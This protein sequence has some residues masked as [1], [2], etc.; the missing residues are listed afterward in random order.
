MNRRTPLWFARAVVAA[1]LVAACGSSTVTSPT[2]T[3]SVA[4]AEPTRSPA[5][6]LRVDGMARVIASA[7]LA[8]SG[9]PD[10]KKADPSAPVLPFGALV[11]LVAGPQTIKGLDWWLVQQDDR[12]APPQFGWVASTDT[13][14]L[15]P[16]SVDCPAVVDVQ[17]I[18]SLGTLVALS[19][20][21]GRDLTLV[22]QVTCTP[23]AVDY[24]VGG[25][26]WLDSY[27]LCQ[28][29]DALAVH[30][31]GLAV[32]GPS[33]GGG[34]GRFEVRG[35]FDDPEAKTCSPIPFGVSV[36]TPVGPPEPAAVLACR[37]MFVVTAATRLG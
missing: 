34:A 33:D 10:P 37:R 22:G 3:A 29:D 35:H 21:G 9:R 18:Q 8:V 19:C 14:T 15:A 11:F 27:R 32:V 36:T 20:F 16:I 30:G 7:G 24:V 6:V 17:V 23:A 25:P 4:S 28:I 1:I 13:D 26:S 31:R 5:P 12:A 2:A